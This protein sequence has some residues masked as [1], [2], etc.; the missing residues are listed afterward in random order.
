M[1][2]EKIKQVS[3]EMLYDDETFF[4]ELRKKYGNDNGQ[5]KFH[6]LEKKIINEVDN[7]SRDNDENEI[8]EKIAVFIRNLKKQI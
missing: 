5:K 2:L 8:S 4:D 1:D 7:L 3:C 6:L